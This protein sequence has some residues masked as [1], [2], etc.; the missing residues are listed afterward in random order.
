MVFSIF[1]ELC[2]HLGKGNDYPLQSSCLNHP[3]DRGAYLI[4]EY[5][6]NNFLVCLCTLH[7]EADCLIE[8][9]KTNIQ[10]YTW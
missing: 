1:A 3:M 5:F 9:F 4:I 6:Q 2:S 7:K 8:Y 10:C